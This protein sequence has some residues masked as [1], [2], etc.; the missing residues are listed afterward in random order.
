MTLRKTTRLG[1]G[2]ALV[3]VLGRPPAGVR[4]YD[5]EDMAVAR[6][7]LTTEAGTIAPWC[8]LL[9]AVSDDSVKD[10][11]KKILR[12]GGNVGLLSFTSDDL[13]IIYAK[14]YRCAPSAAP[15]PPP[16]PGAMPPG[17]AP[18]PG[19]AVPPPGTPPPTPSR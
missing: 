2:L 15:P 19:A 13:S 9:G 6:V 17:A 1:L 10:L 12:S 14:V 16:P 5:W 3:L 4:A 7:F 11:R 18:P 8:R